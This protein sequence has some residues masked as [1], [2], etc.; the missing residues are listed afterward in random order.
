MAKT[1][2][3]CVTREWS[4]ISH[5]NSPMEIW[6]NKIRN[7]RSFLR[8]WAK[9]VSSVHKKEKERLLVLIYFLDKK[10]ETIL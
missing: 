6:Q 1:R 7:L 8:G 5:G 9:N 3:L 10:A 2:G 4:S